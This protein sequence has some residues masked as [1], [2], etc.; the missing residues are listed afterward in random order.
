MSITNPR[1]RISSTALAVI[2]VTAALA[3]ACSSSATDDPCRVEGACNSSK[4]KG[5]VHGVRAD[6]RVD[7][8][9]VQAWPARNLEPAP[10]TRAEIAR[11]CARMGACLVPTDHAPTAKE[12]QDL[13]LLTAICGTPDGTEERVI[14]MGGFNERWS[15]ML[16]ETL[17]A[18]TC[19]DVVAIKTKRAEG[20]GCEEAGCYWSSSTPIPKVTCAGEVATLQTGDKTFVRDC[21]HAYAHCSPTSATGCTDR[22]T[23]ACDPKGI[24]RC[25]GDVKLGCD[26]T[27]RVSF[28]DCALVGRKCVESPQGAQCA[29]LAAETCTVGS[30]CEGAVLSL[31]VGGEKTSV[32]CKAAGFS[33]CSSGHCVP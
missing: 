17:A 25:D 2:A 10:L 9:A 6:G 20:I 11:A 1:H 32:D 3:S 18:K 26:H 14:P 13:G 22:A 29:P 21:S 8:T 28:H 7:V 23:V 19:A 33:S 16:R 31:C 5:E 30:S 4:P 12:D 24:D 27:G 15:Y